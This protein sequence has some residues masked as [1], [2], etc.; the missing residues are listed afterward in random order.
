[1][2]LWSRGGAGGVDLS[3]SQSHVLNGGEVGGQDSAVCREHWGPY[4]DPY[5]TSAQ[6]KRERERVGRTGFKQLLV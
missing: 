5:W 1:M 6:K 4:W 3:M 2:Q